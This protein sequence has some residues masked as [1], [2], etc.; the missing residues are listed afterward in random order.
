MAVM[1]MFPLG[2]ALLPHMPLPLRIFEERYLKL[3]GDLM[4]SDNP[5]FGLSLIH[6]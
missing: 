1:P 6:I 4:L 2:T 5:E 3:L